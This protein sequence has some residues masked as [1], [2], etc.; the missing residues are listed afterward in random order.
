[1]PT[2]D[3]ECGVCGHTCEVFQSITDAR[4]R[5]CPE[6]GKNGLKRLIGAGAGLIFKGAGFYE[7]DYRSEA[8]K[9]KAKADTESSSTSEKSSGESSGESSGK[10]SGGS[11]AKKTAEKSAGKKA[12]KKD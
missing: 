2:Y 6:C 7:T 3:Y 4:K 9:A 10:T 5:K 8:Y 12:D 1:M 11:D